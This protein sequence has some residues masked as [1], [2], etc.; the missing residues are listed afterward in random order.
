M[1][2]GI[3]PLA[4]AMLGL[5]DDPRPQGCRTLSGYDDTFRIRVGRYR[6]LYMIA[7][8]KL[9]VLILKIGHRRDVYR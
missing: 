5:A 1:V 8:T 7:D 3:G 4:A 2:S 9:I 6:L